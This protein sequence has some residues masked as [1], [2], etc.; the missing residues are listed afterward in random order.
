MQRDIQ[1]TAQSANIERMLYCLGS[2]YELFSA[3]L[4]VCH[5]SIV[6]CDDTLLTYTVFSLRGLALND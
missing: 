3:S 1:N 6:S 2:G 5:D 4:A